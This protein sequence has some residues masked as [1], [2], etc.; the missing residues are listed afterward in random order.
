MQG[1]YNRTYLQLSSVN[2]NYLMTY[3]SKRLNQLSPKE[4]D[5]RLDLA[6]RNA[7]EYF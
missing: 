1:V 2:L 6:T 3:E 7:L 4:A 5:N